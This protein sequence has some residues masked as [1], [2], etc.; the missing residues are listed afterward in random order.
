MVLGVAAQATTWFHHLAE[1]MGFP[2][3][4]DEPTELFSDNT[5]AIALATSDILTVQNRFY[6]RIFHYVK[7]CVRSGRVK[8]L[9]VDT[10]DNVSDCYISAIYG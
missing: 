3:W 4:M 1:D 7:E 5:A 6:S 8:V 2:E 10:K 9:K